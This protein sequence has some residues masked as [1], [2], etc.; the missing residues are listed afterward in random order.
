MLRLDAQTA[1]DLLA[2][3]SLDD[4]E[5]LQ[6]AAFLLYAPLRKA[7]ASERLILF[8]DDLDW[9]ALRL[10]DDDPL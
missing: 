4:L 8:V 7:K 10:P 9:F 5:D 6:G 3:H 1:A 2:R